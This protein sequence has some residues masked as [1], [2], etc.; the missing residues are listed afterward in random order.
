MLLLLTLLG[1]ELERAEGEESETW[2]LLAP[3]NF[4][5]FV[6]SLMTDYSFRFCTFGGEEDLS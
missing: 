6:D 5:G 1:L 2:S 4:K 3:I